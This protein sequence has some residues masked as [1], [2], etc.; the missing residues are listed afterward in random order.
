[1]LFALQ[2]KYNPMM[3]K[4]VMNKENEVFGNPPDGIEVIA[5][6]GR[7]GRIHQHC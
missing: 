3:I 5:R 2:G 1:M 4:T 6:Y 7:E